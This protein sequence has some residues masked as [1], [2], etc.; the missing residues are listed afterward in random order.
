MRGQMLI[1]RRFFAF[2]G[3]MKLL[4]AILALLALAAPTLA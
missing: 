3:M 4:S 1:R 2:G